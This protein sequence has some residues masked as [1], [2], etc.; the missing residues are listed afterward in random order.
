M[1][2]YLKLIIFQFLQMKDYFCLDSFLKQALGLKHYILEELNLKL[3][4]KLQGLLS[5]LLHFHLVI[6]L[7][8]G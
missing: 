4:L 5:M 7:F 2:I 1:E 8:Q 6:N 3:V